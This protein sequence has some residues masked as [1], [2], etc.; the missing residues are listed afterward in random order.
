MANALYVPTHLS[1]GYEAWLGPQT[2]R[3]R[4]DDPEGQSRTTN[5]SQILGANHVSGGLHY[6]RWV[7]I[8]ARARLRPHP[9]RRR[10]PR[11]LP[12]VHV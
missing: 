4:R 6:V 7:A 1:E 10:Y 11:P 2:D 5:F 3:N 8:R 9:N 12:G